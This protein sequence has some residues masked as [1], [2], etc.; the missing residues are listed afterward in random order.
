MHVPAGSLSDPT[1]RTG[2][3][4]LAAAFL[5]AAS[6]LLVG[7]GRASAL[8]SASWC[9]ASAPPCVVSATLDGAPFFASDPNYDFGI[10]SYTDRGSSGFSWG[11]LST[12]TGNDLGAGALGQV[13]RVVIDTGT[14]VPRV[15]YAQGANVTFT[16]SPQPAGTYRLTITASPETITDN[17]ECDF[18]GPSP[19]CPFRA[20]R[21]FT[22]YLATQISD[23]NYAGMYTPSQVGSFYGMDMSTNIAETD[24]PPQIVPDPG[25]GT[26]EVVFQLANQHELPDGSRFLGNLHVRLPDSFLS[27]IY[28]ITDP[29]TVTTN[30]LAAS[31]GAGTVSIH[32]VPG[33]GALALDLTGVT[34]SHRT[35]RIR[36]GVVTPTTPLHVRA[37]RLGAHRGKVRFRA[38]HPRG[39]RIAGYR[40]VCTSPHARTSAR[41]H[42]SPITVTGLAA[43]VAYSCAVRAESKAGLGRPSRSVHMPA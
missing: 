20:T 10:V 15:S 32:E 29:S 40:I 27:A 8:S 38:A 41:S 17:N 34:F 28:G 13:W 1:R 21:A 35:L 37:R 6:V 2:C 33:G 16:R 3:R 12:S 9:T 4:T 19:T 23:F 42:G 31:I 14:L 22:A 24:L 39:V 26:N 5:L 11:I 43:G 30:G 7:P 25:T 18:S 36:R